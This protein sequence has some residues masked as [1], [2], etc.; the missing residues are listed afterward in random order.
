MCPNNRDGD[1]DRELLQIL[2]TENRRNCEPAFA[3]DR[4]KGNTDAGAIVWKRIHTRCCLL[5][6]NTRARAHTH[7]HSHTIVD[8]LFSFYHNFSHF[9]RC[10]SYRSSC[11]HSFACMQTFIQFSRFD[12]QR[13]CSERKRRIDFF[14]SFEF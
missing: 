1:T 12:T 2:Y 14:Y 8:S 6:K 7:S 10:F 3:C 4:V 5:F 13:K 11:L 9:P